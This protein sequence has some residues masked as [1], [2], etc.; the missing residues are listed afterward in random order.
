MWSSISLKEWES[1]ST[2][3]AHLD[4][5][6]ARKLVIGL[7]AEAPPAYYSFSIASDEEP[8]EI[9]IISV[10]LGIKP[11]VVRLDA[12]PCALV[13]HDTW[14]SWVDVES[15][16]IV[17][18]RQLAG[19][20][21]EFLSFDRDEVVV[22]HELGALRADASGSIKWSVDTDV[23]ENWRIEAD[24]N[25][26]LSVMDSEAEVAV[27]LKSGGVSPEGDPSHLVLAACGSHPDSR[28]L[29]DPNCAGGR[30]KSKKV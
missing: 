21:Y 7:A 9:G 1:K 27:S 12:G 16:V 17:S 30:P 4:T 8:S 13:G 11:V 15:L 3:L 26:V 29:T 24:D 6:A 28:I 2:L 22:L 5:G 23:V 10:G 18:S 19:A 20:F 25:L 14:L